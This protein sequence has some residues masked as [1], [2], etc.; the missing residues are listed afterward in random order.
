MKRQVENFCVRSDFYI[1]NDRLRTHLCVRVCVCVSE[2]QKELSTL[3]IATFRGSHDERGRAGPSTS[4]LIKGNPIKIND[5]FFRYF[6][7]QYFD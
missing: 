6:C 5:S 7:G 4:L 3:F 2:R 1:F